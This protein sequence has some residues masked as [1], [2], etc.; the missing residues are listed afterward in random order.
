M[1]NI[2]TSLNHKYCIDSPFNCKFF[3]SNYKND[4]I[5][6]RIYQNEIIVIEGLNVTNNVV[7]IENIINFM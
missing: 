4:K 1:N 3:L 6:N 5:I 7:L 2:K